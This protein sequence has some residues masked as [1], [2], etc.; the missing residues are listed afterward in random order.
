VSTP[1][2][3]AQRKGPVVIGY[4]GSPVADRA[5]AEAAWP[6]GLE[7]PVP[8]CRRR[9]ARELEQAA[10]ESAE[11]PARQGAGLALSMGLPAESLGVE[12]R[13][14]RARGAQQS[15]ARVAAWGPPATMSVTI[16]PTSITVTATAS[17]SDP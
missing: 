7:V 8:R 12:D 11:R 10:Y 9:T 14:A 16:S 4:D 15:R 17:S 3:A 13:Q 5:L 6:V 1:P 2:T